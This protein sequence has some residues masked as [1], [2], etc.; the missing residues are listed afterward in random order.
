[1]NEPLARL[2]WSVRSYVLG[3]SRRDAGATAVVCSKSSGKYFPVRK[4][5]LLT[6]G[7]AATFS[8]DLGITT[9]PG[10][11]RNKETFR[12]ER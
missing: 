6:S 10:Y 9:C 3:S 11:S 4:T 1:M 2:L 5:A 7:G 12:R 8:P